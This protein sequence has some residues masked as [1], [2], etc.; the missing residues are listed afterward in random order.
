VMATN[1]SGLVPPRRP[2]RLEE[3]PFS[4]LS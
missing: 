3:H 2:G 4:H 1:T